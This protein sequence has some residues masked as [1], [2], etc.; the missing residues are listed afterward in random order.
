MKPTRALAIAAPVLLGWLAHAALHLAKLSDSYQDDMRQHVLGLNPTPDLFGA[1]FAA[2][3]PA[4]MR[5]VHALTSWAL[6]PLAWARWAQPLLAASVLAWAAW[7]AGRALFAHRGEPGARDAALVMVWASQ[8]LAWAGDDLV[9]GTPRSWALAFTVLAVDAAGRRSLAQLAAAAFAF[10]LF[11]PPLALGTFAV[12]ALMAGARCLGGS[13]RE[14]AK[15]A[16]VAAVALAVLG[17]LAWVQAMP[18]EPFG[19]RITREAAAGMREF[20]LG[21]RAQYFRSDAMEFWIKGERSGVVRPD[22]EIA[23]IV[24]AAALAAAVLWRPSALRGLWARPAWRG[25]A[26][27]GVAGVALFFAAH[28]LWLKLFHPNRH[29]LFL[30]PVAAAAAL[31]AWAGA[32]GWR[33]AVLAGTLLFGSARYAGRDGYRP[34]AETVAV[35]RQLEGA[36]AAVV[37][38]HPASEAASALPLLAGVPVVSSQELTLPY[39]TGFYRAALERMNDTLAAWAAVDPAVL[40]AFVARHRVTH[41]LL[42]P[43]SWPPLVLLPSGKARFD[44]D[45]AAHQRLKL[46]WRRTYLGLLG[47]HKHPI[48]Q[49]L[50]H[51]WKVEAP[52]VAPAAE[53]LAYARSDRWRRPE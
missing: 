41:F 38:A 35:A 9:S 29:V 25:A 7:R 52:R 23:W 36:V 8:A 28:A 50:A 5:G 1:Y 4:G 3:T 2:S 17:A 30:V 37:A 32:G 43:D 31:A 48:L 44:R 47:H 51:E 14:A 39:H 45:A 42:E 21:G 20:G 40:E 46:P 26:L 16:G 53:V 6:S 27:Y 15:A 12:L 24:I 22:N 49:Q 10:A 33:A 18:M 19:P 11:Y 34:G 13:V